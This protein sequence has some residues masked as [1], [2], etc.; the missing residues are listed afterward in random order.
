M[1]NVMKEAVWSN[2][3]RDLDPLMPDHDFLANESNTNALPKL[4]EE[5]FFRNNTIIVRWR[6]SSHW[7]VL[8]LLFMAPGDTDVGTGPRS[9]VH[10]PWLYQIPF[11][12]S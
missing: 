7:L 5:Y 10:L 1:L 6:W 8:L 3:L 9:Y 11:L 4:I 2:F 12:Q